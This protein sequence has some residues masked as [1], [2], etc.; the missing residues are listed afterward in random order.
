V[1]TGA[2]CVTADAVHFLASTD[3]RIGGWVALVPML[4]SQ[5]TVYAAECVSWQPRRSSLFL[6]VLLAEQ[7]THAM[8]DVPP[9][10][11]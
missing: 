7:V 11:A 6:H 9:R 4:R 2:T 8:V 3:S 1:L 5:R 10:D